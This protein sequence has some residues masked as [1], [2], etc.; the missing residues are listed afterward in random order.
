MAKKIKSADTGKFLSKEEAAKLDEATWYE[1]ETFSKKDFLRELYEQIKNHS[2]VSGSEEVV[3]MR[4]VKA[5][6]EE[7]EDIT[8]D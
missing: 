2:F 5:V 1:T 6:F 3:S 7:V 4:N 8:L